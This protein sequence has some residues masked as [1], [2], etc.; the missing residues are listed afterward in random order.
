MM[1]SLLV[2]LF[3]CL[4]V[5]SCVNREDRLAVNESGPGIEITDQNRKVLFFQAHPKSINGQYERAGY[6]H[7]LYDLEGNVLTED[8]PEDHP[9]HRGIFWAWHQIVWRNQKIADGWMSEN[10]S[11]VPVKISSSQ[12]DSTVGIHSAMVWKCK[13][14]GAQPIDIISEKTIITVQQSK[15]GYRIIDFDIMLLP[16]VDSL[17]LGGSDD[18]K[19]YGGFCMR[20]KLPVDMRFTSQGMPV[21]VQ[22]TAVTAGPWM[23]FTGSFNANTSPGSGVALFCKEPFPAPEQLWILRNKTSMQNIPYPGRIPSP[24]SPNGWRF[25]YRLIIHNATVSQEQLQKL[26]MEYVN[27]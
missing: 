15:P 3:C 12:T 10:V 20:L 16:L 18:I 25:Q 21:A 17:S 9:Y 4:S 5:A 23:D 27:R 11:F 26:Y 19:G 1:R 2:I 13:T 22:D 24:L 8:G 14:G 6:I 7:P